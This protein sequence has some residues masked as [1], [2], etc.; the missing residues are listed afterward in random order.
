M[1]KFFHFLID[2]NI[3]ISLAAVVLTI[4][5]QIQLGLSPQW[6][7]YLFI[8]F[9]ATLFEYN[10]HRL[11]TVI[12]NKDAL[13]SDKHNWVKENLG[14]FYFLVFVSVIGLIVAI[15]LAKHEVLMALTPIA[16]I[17]IAYSLPIFKNK[18]TVLRLREIP[19]IKIFLISIVWSAATILLPIIQSDIRFHT[20]DIFAMLMERFFFILAI[21]IP[22]DIR[23]I[24]ADHGVGLKTIPLMVGKKTALLI[25]YVALF[26]FMTISIWHY[27]D[28]K[29]ILLA[30]GISGI[31]TFVFL[32]VQKIQELQK[33]HYGILDGTMLLQGI[34]LLIFYYLN[35]IL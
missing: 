8:I 27:W 28:F 25:A 5:T 23:D 32:S 30:L 6:H 11:I 35:L 13:E 4:A 1:K 31:S 16:I 3:Y 15:L 2:T 17:T 29:F 34:L 9:F 10:L 12:T 21:T 33:Y 14:W 18:T 7:P 20:N 26:V 24:E 22:F 19:L